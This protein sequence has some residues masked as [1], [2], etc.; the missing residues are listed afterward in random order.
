[1]LI[2]SEEVID[3]VI[4]RL[5]VRIE[6]GNEYI[7]QNIGKTIDEMGTLTDTQTHQLIQIMQYGG[8]YDKIVKKISD[9]TK[10]NTKEV[11]EFFDEVAKNNYEF[12]E[13][14][15]KY[16]N[17][18]FI[19]YEQ[20][21]ALK[22]QVQAIAKMT[23]DQYKNIIGSMAF[24]RIGKNGRVYYT[25]IGKMYQEIVDTGVVSISQGK[26]TFDEE[27]YRIIKELGESG[28]R[29]VDYESGKSM[30]VDTAVRMHLKDA[31]TRLHNETQEIYGK[32]FGADG[33]EVSVHLNPAPDHALVQ[34]KQFSD[35]E[36]K[37]FQNDED[38]TSYDGT[39]F[40]AEAEETGHD[41]RSIGQYNC[42]HK[43]FP[44]ILGAS[45]PD[46]TDEQL[47]EILDK[48]NEGF[49][50]EG[51]H[52]TNYEGTQLQRKLE[53]RIREE[54]DKQILAKASGNE[55]AKEIIDKS[56]QK[57][58]ELTKK[59]RDLSKASGLP[60]YME[61]LRVSG[62]KRVAKNKLK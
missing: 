46:Y 40:P 36:F 37:K 18:K 7:L 55:E 30:R 26:Q 49:K 24:S 5:V 58:T 60:T 13:Q 45:K 43:I 50:F 20:N 19:P 11:E 39:F 25:K 53:T 32:E 34:G 6:D 54:K 62:Y 17:K 35:E 41:R 51:K 16:R 3:K 10:V 21:E 22:R 29:S 27:M 56:Q 8:D 15:Y 47:Q 52:Y 59:Y 48:N 33:I 38:S 44:I 31:V 23:N 28:I 61:N 12:A 9:I 42:Y 4:E 1:M 2:L 57:I 14:F